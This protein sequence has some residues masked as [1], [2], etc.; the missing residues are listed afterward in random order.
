MK[1]PRLWI[2]ALV[3]VVVVGAAVVAFWPRSKVPVVEERAQQI[4]AAVNAADRE[5][6]TELLNYDVAADTLLQDATGTTV[7][8]EPG[9]VV[10][11]GDG[12]Y[13]VTLTTASGEQ[14]VIYMS[15]DN[16]TWGQAAVP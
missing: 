15:Y 1:S 6:L 8:F 12:S 16:G 10:D 14:L 4:A 2:L 3:A 11:Q 7:T 13:M 9:G 5:Q